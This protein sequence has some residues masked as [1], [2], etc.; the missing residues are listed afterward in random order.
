[1]ISLR[2]IIMVKVDIDKDVCIGCGTCAQV[3]PSNW[4]MDGDKA[5]PKDRE[6]KTIGCNQ[7]AADS[8]PVLCITIKK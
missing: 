5:E 7:A 4:M 1:M 8:C 3:C 2:D 6:P